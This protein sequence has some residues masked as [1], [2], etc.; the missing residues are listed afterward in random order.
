MGGERWGDGDKTS[1]VYP[2][3]HQ[4]E[5]TVGSF[6]EKS[7]AGFQGNLTMHSSILGKTYYFQLICVPYA[8]GGKLYKDDL[9]GCAVVS[10]E[11]R[12]RSCHT[13]HRSACPASGSSIL[14]TDTVVLTLPQDA[15]A[16]SS[17]ALFRGWGGCFLSLN[18]APGLT[19][20]LSS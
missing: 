15:P 1:K 2:L 7:T 18:C 6:S 4:K 13:E 9:E 10:Q 20:E 11:C 19:T 12:E 16:V 5:P 8:K 17:I 14:Q 3:A